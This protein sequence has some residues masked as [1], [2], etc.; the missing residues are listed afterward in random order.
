[1]FFRDIEFIPHDSFILEKMMKHVQRVDHWLAGLLDRIG[2]QPLEKE[3]PTLK[4]WAE[5]EMMVKVVGN[6]DLRVKN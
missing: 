5:A 2:V 3:I 6:L 4:R 1:M